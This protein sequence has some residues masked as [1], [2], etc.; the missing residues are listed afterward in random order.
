MNAEKDWLTMLA[1]ASNYADLQVAFD[2]MSVESETAVDGDAMVASI[3]EAIRRI[4]RERASDQAELAGFSSEYEA[5]KKEQSGVIGWFKRKLPFTETRKQELGHRDALSDQA[6]EILADNFI[7]ARAQMLRERVASPKLRRMGQQASYWRSRLLQN[8]SVASIREYGSVVYELGKEI[9]VAKLFVDAVL[10]DIE[11]F[12]GAKFINKEDQ[13]RRNDDLIDEKSELKEL[14]D[15]SH[16]KAN[17]RDSALVSLRNLLVSELSE[18]DI[19]FRN[20]NN[21]L[22]LLKNIQE[23]YPRLAK[24]MEERLAMVKTLV[25]TMVERDSLPERRDKLEKAV[26]ILKSDWEDVEQ[27]RLRA[28]R[29]LEGPSQLYNGALR[30]TQQAKAALNAAKPLYD[31]YIAEQN[32]AAQN[33]AEVTSD[34]DFEVST[35]NVL[36]EYRRL[37]EAASVSAQMLRQRTPTFEHANRN[38]ENAVNEAK[39]IREKSDAHAM[40]LKKISNLEAESQQQMLRA[41]QS[42]E[43]TLPEFRIAAES[44]LDDAN[45]ITRSD[46]SGTSLRFIQELLNDSIDLILPPAPFSFERSSTHSATTKGLAELRRDSE[47][48]AHAINALEVDHKECLNKVT[49]MS[50]VRKEALRARGQLLFDQSVCSELDLE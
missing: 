6:A 47:R 7:I 22:S 32:R 31:A 46:A 43:S 1:Q 10:I 41:K 15:E 19:D 40:D 44:Y 42:V 12:S 23:K 4:E 28:V 9:S 5:F 29:D 45:K 36:T 8:D 38:H 17:I 21:R 49:A 18:K 26:N 35:A 37:E 33:A 39:T 48:L 34:S 2:R 30:E 50:N 3:D 11:A 27:K 25:A 24:L 16:E 20:A 13:L 14:V